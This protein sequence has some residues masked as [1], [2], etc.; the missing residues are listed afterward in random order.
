MKYNLN[1]QKC[2]GSVVKAFTHMCKIVVSFKTAG[3]VEFKTFV[4]H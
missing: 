1:S 2:H 4:K 3:F